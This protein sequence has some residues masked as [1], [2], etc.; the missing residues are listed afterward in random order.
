MRIAKITNYIFQESKPTKG[1]IAFVFGT[2]SWEEPLKTAIKLYKKGTVSLIVFSGGVNKATGINE[3]KIMFKNAIRQGVKKKDII[4]EDRSTNT[5]E[6]VLF[7]KDLIDQKIGLHK[8]RII[9]AVVKNYHAR[10]SLMTL[11]KHFPSYV[12]FKAVPYSLYGFNKKNWYL[13]EKGRE[14]VLGEVEKI[15]K[16]LKKGDLQELIVKI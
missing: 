16:Y 9:I 15:K 3:S 11:K 14:K 7:S 1:D 13:T 6:N 10:G 8:I 12:E 4:V 2:K 5:L